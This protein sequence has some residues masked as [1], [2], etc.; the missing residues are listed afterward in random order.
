M[1]T[2]T[3]KMQWRGGRQRGGVGK[4]SSKRKGELAT[5]NL[6]NLSY[7]GDEIIIFFLVTSQV[8]RVYYKLLES[9]KSCLSYQFVPESCTVDAQHVFTE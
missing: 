6:P 2:F 3:W 7:T 8:P 5:P 4:P 9:Q 1:K